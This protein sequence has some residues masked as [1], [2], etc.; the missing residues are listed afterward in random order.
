MPKVDVD[1][2]HLMVDLARMYDSSS[3]MVVSEVFG[4]AVD[5]SA[6]K[7]DVTLGSDSEGKYV[8]FVNNGPAMSKEDF[9]NYNTLARSSKQFGEG[10]GW[11]G[12]GAKLYLGVWQDSKIITTSSDGITTTATELYFTK[13]NQLWW[14]YVQSPEKFQGTS[15]KAYLTDEDYVTLETQLEEIIQKLFNSAMLNGMIVTVN[16]KIVQPWKPKTLDII[17]CVLAIGKIKLPYKVLITDSNIPPSRCNIEYHVSGK[18]IV[19]K[20]PKNLLSDVKTEYK[21]RF[22][23]IVDAKC[24]SDQLKTNKHNFTPGIFTADVEPG[25]EKELYRILKERDWLDDPTKTKTMKNK[26]SKVMQRLLKKNFPEMKLISHLGKGVGGGGTQQG[27]GSTLPG[28]K[29]S[30]TSREPSGKTRKPKIPRRNSGFS[31]TTT[32]KPG[33]NRQG[34]IDVGTNQIVIN[35][36]HRVA[37]PPMKTRDGRHYHTLRII[38][39]QVGKF[40]SR[41]GKISVEDAF[42]RVDQLFDDM[43]G[44]DIYDYKTPQSFDKLVGDDNKNE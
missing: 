8:K 29:Q 39:S 41:T 12:I 20:K 7:L 43:S 44:A 16:D 36:G 31:F 17:D 3:E 40:V 35:L 23:V 37:G 27:P 33:D 10:L 42:D 14:D 9:V 24:I 26:F 6:T 30:L 32:V 11:A 5:I 1:T 38:A 15:Y 19:I 22:Y 21:K 13:E 2:D 18:C 25:I 34:W 4:N 28:M